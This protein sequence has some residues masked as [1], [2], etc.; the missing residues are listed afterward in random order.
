MNSAGTQH[1]D[2]AVILLVVTAKA[3][4]GSSQVTRWTPP[5]IAAASDSLALPATALG[6]GSGAHLAVAGDF[7][8]TLALEMTWWRTSSHSREASGVTAS[9]AD[10][11]AAGRLGDALLCA[12]DQ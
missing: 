4:T 3:E 9:V 10:A 6:R 11:I 1:R 8:T 2:K 5:L 7:S 12:L